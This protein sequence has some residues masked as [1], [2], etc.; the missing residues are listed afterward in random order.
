MPVTAAPAEAT[1]NGAQP[2]WRR[3]WL[4]VGVL[5]I[6][7]VFAF[8]LWRGASTFYYVLMAWFAALAMEP[9]VARLARRMSRGLATGLVMLLAAVF[10]VI[11][12]GLFGALFVEQLTS[13]IAAVPSMAADALA[14]FNRVSGSTFTFDTIL[15]SI[16][17]SPSDL[18]AYADDLALGVL[19]IV[20]A[21]LSG[22]FGVFVLLFFVFYVSAG[23]PALR[24]WLAH[25]IRPNLQV[26]FLAAWDLTR[27]KVGGY[28]ASRVVLAAINA[29]ASG[30]VFAVIGLP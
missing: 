14:W 22:F 4:V 11:F 5:V 17:L 26:P 28:I 10:L 24:V 6:A 18:T 3:S 13:F 23:M 20:A 12:L 15:D 30:I 25:R 27:I 8:V 19:G 16:G 7:G 29:T 2:L 21:V 9:L 1:P